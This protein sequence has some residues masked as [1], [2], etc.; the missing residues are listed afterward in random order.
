M[1]AK[2]FPHPLFSALLAVIW[3]LLAASYSAGQVLLA[4]LV[5]WGLP[6]FSS[7]LWPRRPPLA[8]PL[9]MLGFIAT[10]L[11]DIVIANVVVALLIL[12]PSRRLKPAFVVYPLALEDRLAITV[13][14][15]TISLT[16]GT[17]SADV[18][19]TRHALLIH[20]LNVEDEEELVRSI[21]ERYEK[22]L[23]EIFG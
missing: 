5:G 16:P 17:V 19:L 10:V 13:L 14:A 15:N 3:L 7:A 11:Y 4:L 12:G 9:A 21:R 8:K 1:F 23:Q 22:P 6:F 20:A 2:L 18:S